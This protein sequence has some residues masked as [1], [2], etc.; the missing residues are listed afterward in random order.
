MHHLTPYLKSRYLSHRR[1]VTPG[2]SYWHNIVAM[3]VLLSGFFFGPAAM[4]AAAVRP[5]ADRPPTVD[6]TYGLPRPATFSHKTVA[7]AWI[8]TAQTRNNQIIYLRHSFRLKTVPRQT[9]LYATA[10]NHLEIFLNGRKVADTFHKHNQVWRHARKVA[11]AA[12]LHSG[13]NTIAIRAKMI[14]HGPVC[15]CG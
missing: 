10:D 12:F 6:P 5:W 15:W 3:T 11:V 13:D 9:E 8:W 7:P 14:R 1:M 4:A 2:F